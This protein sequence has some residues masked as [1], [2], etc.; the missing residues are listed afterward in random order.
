LVTWVLMSKQTRAFG[1]R[2]WTSAPSHREFLRVG[3]AAALS[4][5]AE[6]SA[7]SG[8]TIIAARSGGEAVASYQILLNLLAVVFMVSLGM[9]T[10]T[11]VLT[12]DGI[13]RASPRDASRASWTGLGLNCA[14]IAIIALVLLCFARAVA[15]AYTRDIRIATLVAGAMPIAAAILLPD[16][17][18]VV[19]AAALRAHGDN[20]FPTASHVV[21]YAL[22]MPA[23]GIGLGEVAGLG[24]AGLLQAIVWS[25][26]LSASVL[27]AR[28]WVITRRV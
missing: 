26:L 28:L 16:G 10:A 9:S 6:A 23:L 25:S 22:L 2:R 11:T 20:W 21:A 7:F 24:V 8:M 12:S 14:V 15:A 1:V 27:T 3:G 17:G 13:G 5:A 18:Q 19:S 4:Q